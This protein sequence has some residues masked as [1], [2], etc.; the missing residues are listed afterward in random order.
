MLKKI[1]PYPSPTSP[2]VTENS[3][4][5]L[6]KWDPIV[7]LRKTAARLCVVYS[8]CTSI[9]IFLLHTIKVLCPFKEVEQSN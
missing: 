2:S 8:V 9:A 4:E 6:P 1:C 3:D 5:S 7:R